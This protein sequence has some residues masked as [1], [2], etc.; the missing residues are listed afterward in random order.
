MNRLIP[1]IAA[2][3]LLAF[4]LPG[5]AQVPNRRWIVQTSDGK[6]LG[7]T[8]DQD[9]DPPDPAFATFVL[10]SVIRMADPPG[11]T[12]DITPLG[13]WVVTGGVGVYTAPSGGGIIPPPYDPT[14]DSGMVKDAANDMMDVFD[15]AIAFIRENRAVWRPAAV[16]KAVTGIH[17]QIV[18]SARLALNSTRTHARRQKFLEESASWPAETNGNVVDY[19]DVFNADRH[20]RD[21]DQGFL[22]GRSPTR[23]LHP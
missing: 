3:V 5:E 7:L 23:P 22:L 15:A 19:V 9:V 11:A 1:V 18:N 10:E 2:F 14:S 6:I 8:D 13:T 4:A 16:A 12:G 17:W 21:S 20:D